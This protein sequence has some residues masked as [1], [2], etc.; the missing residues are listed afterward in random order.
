M[1]FKSL[2]RIARCKRF[3]TSE[4]EALTCDLI[5]VKLENSSERNHGLVQVNTADRVVAAFDKSYFPEKAII[6]FELPP[7]AVA[8]RKATAI[9][10]HASSLKK[11]T[12][13]ESVSASTV[14]KSVLKKSSVNAVTTSSTERNNP[15]AAAAG[16]TVGSSSNSKN[17]N[18]NNTINP[19]TGSL[20]LPV[21]LSN[22]NSEDSQEQSTS[23]SSMRGAGVVRT[24]PRIAGPRASVSFQIPKKVNSGEKFFYST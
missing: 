9:A 4:I 21:A 17:N 15:A 24:D 23:T 22:R 14:K 10:A 3:R 20:Q 12:Q 8:G 6:W 11:K 16:E 7:S 18:N 19:T 5:S 13:L 2:D 1:T